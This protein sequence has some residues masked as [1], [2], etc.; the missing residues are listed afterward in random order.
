[1]TD[2]FPFLPTPPDQSLIYV[3]SYHPGW[4]VVSV[5]LAILASYA[6]LHAA[7][8]VEHLQNSKAKLIWI[9]IGVLTLGVGIWAMHFIGMLALNLPCAI[10]YD[11]FTTLISM[12]PGFFASSVA[13]GIAWNRGAKRLP[14]WMGGFLFGA[15][16]GTMHY[17]GMAAMRL[18]GF[19]RYDPFLFLLSIGV[20]VALAY[21]ALRIKNGLLQMEKHGDALIAILMGS[22]VAGMHYTAMSAAYFVRG[23]VA[24]L[25]PSLFT[26]Q[27]LAI[28]VAGTTLFLALGALALATISR[29]KEITDNL[30]TSEERW[31]FALEGAGDGVWDWAPQTGEAVLSQRWKEIIGYSEQEFPNTREAWVE[32]LHPDDRERVLS[33]G[34]DYLAGKQPLYVSEFRMRCKNGSWK[35][36]LSRGKLI[37]SDTT[38][39]PLRMIGTHTDITERKRAEADLRIASVAFESQECITVTDADGI[40]LQVNKAFTACCGY[41]GEDA[42]GHTLRLLKS[43]R[44]GADFYIEMW[45]TLQRTGAW[46]GEL[47]NRRKNGEIYPAWLSITAIKGKD[48]VVT[49]FIGSHTDITERKAAE[50]KI[51]YLAFYDFLTHLPNRRLLMDRLKHALASSER[52]GKGGALL[53][54]DLDNFKTLNDTLGHEIGDL[55]LQQVA[56]RLSACVRESDTVARLGGD[57]FVVMLE[58]LSA[59]TF[60]AAA[61]TK[62]VGE[63]ILAALNLTYRLAMTDYHSTTS[64]GATLFGNRQ[65]SLDDLMKQ[66]D[67]AM[68]QAKKTG[69]NA[70][71]FFDPKMAANIMARV[72]LENELRTALEKHQFHLLYQIQM[73]NHRR[74]IGAEVLLRWKHPEHGMI[75]PM[76]FISLAEDT[77]LIVPIGLWVL[78]SACARLNEWRDHAV[79]RNLTLAVNVS[80]RQFQQTDFVDKVAAVLRDCDVDPTHLKM[81]LTESIVMENIEETISKMQALKQLGISFSLDDFGTGYSSLQYLKRLPLDQIKIDQSFVRDISTDQSDAAIVQTIIAMSDVLG[82]HVIAEGV[83]TEAQREFLELR[84]CH[85]YQGYLFGKPLPLDDF[86]KSVQRHETLACADPLIRK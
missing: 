48:G 66:A 14:A 67:I 30:R 20:A 65:S 75:L 7:S 82:L 81:E 24:D 72:S 68:Y 23:N 79:A 70:L 18:E 33:A 28:L 64:I 16:V 57:E 26:T 13:L 59:Q 41:T 2:T 73:D 1:M 36:I 71:C 74:P 85:A 86:L 31:K 46:Q 42:V 22:A 76:E 21:L 44:H 6:A 34:E 19:V 4:V 38:G 47:W 5:L 17:T 58:N 53:F 69:R 8:R 54:I 83:E 15:A 35:W 52:S 63:K 55:L 50:E 43:G 60:Q 45:A 40:I 49:H 84:G 3:G 77:G 62:I 27:N 29:N 10:Q 37:R 51:Q 61:Q 78:Q 9:V 39:E 25:P 56:Q 12:I 80:I 32:H 11:P